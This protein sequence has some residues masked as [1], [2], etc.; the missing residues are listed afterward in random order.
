MNHYEISPTEPLH[1][2]KGHFANIIDETLE[3]G[4]RDVKRAVKEVKDTLLNKETVSQKRYYNDLFE[5]K[6]IEA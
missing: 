1:D 3:I 6:R 2:L 5:A 4:N